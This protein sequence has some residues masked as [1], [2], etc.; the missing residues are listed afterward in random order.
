MSP[1]QDATY[2]KHEKLKSRKSIEALFAG[3]QSVSKY[4]LRLVYAP[5]VFEDGST[6]KIGVSV[7]KRIFKRA[8]DRNFYKRLL[9]EAYRLNKHRLC[10]NLDQPYAFMLI[11]Q[12]KERA[13]F[14]TV[15]LKAQQLF[16]KFHHSLQP[17][18]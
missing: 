9:R 5:E 16:E 14:A 13:D 12:G 10:Q 7:S 4:P 11:Y 3:A 2:P 18:D 6:H 15:N 8:H 17:K 1:K